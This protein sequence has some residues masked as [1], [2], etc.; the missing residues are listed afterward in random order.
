MCG[1][2]GFLSHQLTDKANAMT[3]LHKMLLPLQHRGPDDQGVWVAP[4]QHIALGHRRLSIIDLSTLASQP[5]L[6]ACGRYCLVFNGEIYN[7][8]SLRTELETLGQVFSSTSDTEVLLVAISQWGLET[9]LSKCNGM[10]AIAL[11]DKQCQTLSL[12]RDRMGEKPVYYG[13]N[14]EYFLF[15][16][17]LSALK[18]HRQFKPVINRQALTLYL[19]YGYIPTPYSIY[20][21]IYKLPPASFIEINLRQKSLP[22]AK[23]YWSTQ[24]A[25]QTPCDL[26]FTEAKQQLNTLLLDAVD[27]RM[28]AD[29][30]LGAFLSGGFDSSLVVALMQAQSMNKVKTFSLGFYEQRYNE[31]QHAQAVAKYLKTD[32]TELYVTPKQ[33]M[34]II[35]DLAGIYKEPFADSSQIP[36][37]LVCKLARSK[38][39]VSL[40]GD[41]GDE[42]FGGYKRYF[43]LQQDW[44]K[45]TQL[46]LGSRQFLVKLLK[47]CPAIVFEKVFSLT[48]KILP[49]KFQKVDLATKIAHL[50]RRLSYQSGEQLYLEL[51]SQWEQPEQIVLNTT[52]PKT[53][54]HQSATV[55]MEALL[56][57][58]M[59]L[60]AV[61]YLPDDILVKVDRASMAVSLEARVPLLDHRVV[62]FAAALPLPYKMQQNTGKR[63]LREVLYDYIPRDLMD[64]PKMGFGVPI[65]YWLR[66]DL[67][68]WAEDLLNPVTLKQQGYFNPDAILTKWQQHLSGKQDWH[69]DLWN[70][71]MFQ[72]WLQASH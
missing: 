7:F 2:A 22:H 27:L 26:S 9:A 38:V 69:Y 10:F 58:V 59:Y 71:L 67:R 13:W 55:A 53:L 40:S 14:Q 24:T 29:V 46:S 6:S 70:I 1:I 48:K 62:E 66:A 60:D 43:W 36:T 65:D 64:R 12:A 16:S 23:F 21:H 45:I 72:S 37:F 50:S 57:Q 30:P 5:M 54:I 18:A 25:Y 34:E 15:A 49:K 44:Q 56:Q 31:A 52:E 3:D 63:V 41:G 19:R 42:L 33:A 8:K 32:H 47:V 51:I 4:Q 68:E 35:P 17:E 20:Q 61:T 28:V 11:W 39:T